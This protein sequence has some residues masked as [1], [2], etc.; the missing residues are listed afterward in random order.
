MLYLLFLPL[1]L[2]ESITQTKSKD[3]TPEFRFLQIQTNVTPPPPP[4]PNIRG[5]LAPIIPLYKPQQTGHIHK[6]PDVRKT[7]P[8]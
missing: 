7:Y 2:Y 4:P 1:L 6:K 5:T 3:Q 8:F